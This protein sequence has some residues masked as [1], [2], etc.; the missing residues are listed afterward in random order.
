L[1]PPPAHGLDQIA[2]CEAAHGASAPEVQAAT[3]GLRNVLAGRSG[4]F[5]LDYGSAAPV[6]RRWFRLQVVP[7]DWEGQPAALLMH[8][9]IT[10]LR[11]ARDEVL[12]LNANLERRVQRRTRQLESANRDLENANRE[13]EAFSYS[14]SHDLKAPLAAVDGFTQALQER[15]QGRLEE[16]E[17]GYLERVRAGVGS[18]W[19]LIDAMLA[20]HQVSRP[21]PLRLADIDVSQ[22]A[23]AV[24]DELRAGEPDRLAEVDIEP[25]IR[26][27]CDAALMAIVLRNLLGNAWK[28]SAGKPVVRI[29]VGQDWDS[30]AGTTTLRISDA[31]A[32]FDPQHAE[33]LFVPFQRLHYSHEFPGTGVGLATVDRIVQ[34]HGGSVRAKGV[35]DA[36]ATFWVTLPDA[37]G[38]DSSR[39][40]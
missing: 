13:L 40:D 37:Q 29:T 1:E 30:P 4:E 39:E 6:A 35:P 11:Q 8:T 28:F 38:F 2:A 16:R 14:V 17:A 18:M 31:G 21:A 12:R 3:A 33:R 36:G 7:V 20:L 10:A 22:L 27:H 15:L 34:R 26:M 5:T 9:D 32:G 25:A 24:V 19:T 23:R